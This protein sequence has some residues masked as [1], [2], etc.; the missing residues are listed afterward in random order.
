MSSI[1][2]AMAL[3]L[4]FF[5]QR[6]NSPIL[7]PP[8]HLFSR[9][10]VRRQ[11]VEPAQLSQ[12]LAFS[13]SPQPLVHLA[14]TLWARLNLSRPQPGLRVYFCPDRRDILDRGCITRNRVRHVDFSAQGMYL[15]SRATT[16]DGSASRDFHF[17]TRPHSFPLSFCDPTRPGRSFPSPLGHL[18]F[19]RT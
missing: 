16:V 13:A 18:A 3:V 14:P 5:Q 1:G 11:L 8:L 15:P 4:T 19:S 17:F 10:F 9:Q 12:Q 6:R 7:L 2:S